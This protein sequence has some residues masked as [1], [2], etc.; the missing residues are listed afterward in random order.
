M[1]PDVF[2]GSQ[3]LRW[4]QGLV[5]LMTLTRAAQIDIISSRLVLSKSPGL[6]THMINPA[7]FLL[8]YRF[9]FPD[10]NTLG[11]GT[12]HGVWLGDQSKTRLAK[13][14]PPWP[15]PC[16]GGSIISF[17]PDKGGPGGLHG[18]FYKKMCLF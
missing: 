5:K 6:G 9:R 13:N 7:Q 4:N 10:P 2:S 17:P 14:N 8:A 12:F 1:T 18:E 15:P 3:V 16:Q 11:I